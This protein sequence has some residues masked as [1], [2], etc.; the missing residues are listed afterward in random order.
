MQSSL[1]FTADGS[2]D[3]YI[4]VE[5][6]N[7]GNGGT[8]VLNV[9]AS[10]SLVTLTPTSL[11][12]GDQVQGTTS[13]VQT[14]T[15]AN[16][17]SIPVSVGSVAIT[18]TDA[19][20]FEIISQ[21]C[22]GN[23]VPSVG[24]C[25]ISIVFLPQ[26][27]G[28]RQANL[29]FNDDATG[30]PRVVPLSGTGTPPA[31]LVCLGASGPL[32]F[33]N[34]AVGVTSAALTL[35]VT[36]CGTAPLHIS[37]A[38]LSGTG[39][40]DF[41]VTPACTATT[42]VPPGVTCNLSI[43]FTPTAAG[44][45][46]ATL[47]IASDISDSPTTILL[48]GTGFIPAPALCPSLGSVN[49][50]GVGVGITS[51]VQT[52]TITNCGTAPLVISNNITIT[53]I[54]TGEFFIV[55]TN[56]ATVATNSFCQIG[57]RFAPTNGGPRSAT[58]SIADNIAG[59][60]QL[61]TLTGTGDLSQPDAA[62]GKNTKLKKMVG[63]GTN[64]T[65]GAGQEL[66]QKVSRGARKG[67]RY[68]VAVKNIGSGYDRFLVQ[69]QCVGSCAGF[70]VNYFIGA[71][72]SESV[73]VTAAVGAATFGTGTMGP[74]A[75]TGDAT[76]IRVEVF[77]AKTVSKGVTGAFTLTFSSASD[78]TKQDTVRITAIAK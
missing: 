42:S 25:L 36:N 50:G 13:A 55:S 10:A 52:L 46:Q 68:F 62:I 12:F 77:A 54:S 70:T 56:C 58:L 39:A 6:H 43:T 24:N 48:Q 49:F 19:S 41:S 73:D 74:G 18:G 14:V 20:D 15:Y 59:S 1:S 11:S 28:A 17:Y 7:D 57:L 47:T 27:V 40:G 63:F 45:R 53:G 4:V 30:S 9:N 38:T 69:S 76:M 51:A 5:P 31:P 72:P 33:T 16:G 8:L 60:P 35:I 32:V 29:V 75:V 22:E 61:V 37:S 65:T 21:T 44:T 2:N 71:K 66:V 23:I 3:Y 26:D 67:R 78:P 34:T 64:D